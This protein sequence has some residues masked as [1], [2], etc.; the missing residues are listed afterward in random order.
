[1]EKNLKNNRYDRLR[2][3]SG[4]LAKASGCSDVYVRQVL[5]G[6]RTPKSIRASKAVLVLTKAEELLT[7]INNITNKTV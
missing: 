5:Q 3:M 2:G 6:Q 4:L 7:T 1:M